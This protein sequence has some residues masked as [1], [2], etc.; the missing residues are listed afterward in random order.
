MSDN[1]E[2]KPVVSPYGF[3]DII[4]RFYDF[5]DKLGTRKTVHAVVWFVIA[6]VLAIAA[7]LPLPA[8]LSWITPIVGIPAG[9]IIF[10]LGL[11]VVHST[12]LKYWAMFQVKEKY[13]QRRRVVPALF[14]AGAV[15]AVLIISAGV[16]PTGVGGAIIVATALTVYNVIRRTPYEI[17]LANKGIPDPREYSEEE[18]E[19]DYEPD[20]LVEEDDDI[21]NERP[22]PTGNQRGQEYKGRLQ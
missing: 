4:R 22:F 12:K 2:D 13:S 15:V 8:G 1:S 9:I 5:V 10:A 19:E 11:G 16:I 14:G 18:Y 21:L 17:E 7:S 6:I 3:E 20:V